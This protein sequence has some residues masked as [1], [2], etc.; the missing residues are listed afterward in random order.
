MALGF[1]DSSLVATIIAIDNEAEATAYLRNFFGD[2][3][4]LITEFIRLR[5]PPKKRVENNRKKGTNKG[6]PFEPPSFITTKPKKKG[7]KD[8]NA[9][10]TPEPAVPSFRPKSPETPQS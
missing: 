1:S 7:K 4:A 3:Q 5:F 10:L 8:R 2:N 9:N 6:R